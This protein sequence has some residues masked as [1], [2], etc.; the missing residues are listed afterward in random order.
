VGATPMRTRAVLLSGMFQSSPTVASGCDGGR[1]GPSR[2][3]GAVSILTHRGKWV[4][5]GSSTSSSRAVRFQSSPTVA[6]G[7]DAAVVIPIV[8]AI[9]GFQ[10]SP[11]VAS[12]CDPPLPRCSVP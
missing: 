4:R 5:R 10:S 11:T 1:P 7:C 6:S 3:G 9:F 8:A 12:G 2:P